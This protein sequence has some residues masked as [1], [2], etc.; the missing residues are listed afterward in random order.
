MVACLT[1]FKNHQGLCVAVDRQILTWQEGRTACQ[2]MGGDLLTLSSPTDY[3]M[4]LDFLSA[5]SFKVYVC[6]VHK[7]PTYSIY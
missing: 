7:N 3:G 4:I 2:A 1:G 5:G 6:N